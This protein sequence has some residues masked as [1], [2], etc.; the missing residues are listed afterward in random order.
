M[1]IYSK[2][3]DDA[4]TH[5]ERMQL[6]NHP[7]LKPVTVD[8]LFIFDD[9]HSSEPVLTH[10]GYGAAAVVRIT[11]VRDRAL[12]GAD[13]IIIIDRAIWVT[14]TAAQRDALIDHELYHLE[15]RHDKDGN[16]KADGLG[17]PK[18]GMRRHD[19]QFGWFDEIAR[20]HGDASMEIRQ[21]RLLLAGSGQ[22]YFDFERIVVGREVSGSIAGTNEVA[23]QRIID[24][25]GK[26][27]NA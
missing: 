6:E 21:A 4:L 7:D 23:T 25:L 10:Q 11:P 24:G 2:A 17:R 3:S 15:W 12:G 8:A 9:E 14:L 5:I 26:Q 18:L 22:L 16:P 19:H 13:A 27:P 1:K 20:R